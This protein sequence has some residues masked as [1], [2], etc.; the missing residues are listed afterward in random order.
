[1][2]SPQEIEVWYILPSLRK[3]LAEEMLKMGLKQKDIASKLHV[4]NSAV[5][6]YIKSKR[7]TN[8][9]FTPDIRKLISSS[10]YRIVNAK[11][12]VLVEIQKLCTKIRSNGFLCKIHKKHSKCN[13]KNCK[14]CN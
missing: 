2:E 5:S 3:A 12:N 10:A 13:L 9:K 14:V 11:A 8:V 6:Q 7:A 1:M 4:T